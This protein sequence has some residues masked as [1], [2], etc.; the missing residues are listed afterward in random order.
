MAAKTTTAEGQQRLSGDDQR[1]RSAE[2][3]SERCNTLLSELTPEIPDIAPALTAKIIARVIHRNSD[4]VREIEV[5]PQQRAVADPGQ[6]LD[7]VSRFRHTFVIDRLGEV[8]DDHG[9]DLH[10]EHNGHGGHPPHEAL[11]R[12]VSRYDDRGVERDGG[13]RS[14]RSPPAVGEE[15]AKAFVPDCSDQLGVV[16]SQWL[17]PVQA[18]LV[19]S[20]CEVWCSFPESVSRP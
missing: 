10:R 4:V 20:N 7:P 5:E 16:G 12:L 9:R 15:E 18:R 6:D 8:W 3:T 11:W 1:R 2:R 13:E 17:H 19:S 14:E